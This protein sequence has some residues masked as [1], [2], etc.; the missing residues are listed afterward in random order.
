MGF[1]KDILF[2][3]LH[4]VGSANRLTGEDRGTPT[5]RGTTVARYPLLLV[6]LALSQTACNVTK[7]LDTVKGERLLVKNKLEI[8]GV[9]KI[10]Y[11]QRSAISYA[12]E[13]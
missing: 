12:L 10:R 13:P 3:I 5:A 7:H 4:F 6:L 11:N 2:K 1:F 8:K 9:Q